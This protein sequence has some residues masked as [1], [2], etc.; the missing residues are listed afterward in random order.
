MHNKQELTARYLLLTASFP[1]CRSMALALACMHLIATSD[2][3]K[4]GSDS[5]LL[6]TFLATFTGQDALPA[7]HNTWTATEVS[8]QL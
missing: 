6:C 7:M 5:Q 1:G 4:S 2:P 8:M 3:I